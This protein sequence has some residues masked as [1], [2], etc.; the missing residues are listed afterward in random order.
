[1][2]L[3]LK[4]QFVSL[5]ESAQTSTD[6]LLTSELCGLKKTKRTFSLTLFLRPHGLQ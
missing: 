4:S 6:F 5:D 3:Q 2:D 1:M